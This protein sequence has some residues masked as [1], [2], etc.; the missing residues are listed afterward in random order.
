MT[1]T[2]TQVEL[3]E[4]IEDVGGVAQPLLQV[5][6]LT[7]VTTAEAM[8]VPSAHPAIPQLFQ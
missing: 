8:E 1:E 2:S 3:L 7:Q 6:G 5:V 4:K